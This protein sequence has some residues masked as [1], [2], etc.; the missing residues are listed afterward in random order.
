M[1]TTD[2]LCSD[3]VLD[4]AYGWLCEQ[5]RRW[6]DAADMWSFRRDW[7]A[8]KLRL[9]AELCSGRFGVQERV[10]HANGEQIDLWSARDAL[11]LKALALV[12]GEPLPLSPLVFVCD[13]AASVGSR[14]RQA[15]NEDDVVAVRRARVA[16]HLDNE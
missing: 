9:Q 12:L 4:R 13:R 14:R 10:T 1:K 15:G 2:R 5:R 3:A 11:V 16:V 7:V 6:P 8:E